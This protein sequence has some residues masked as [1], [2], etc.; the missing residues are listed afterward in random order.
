MQFT[1]LFA[2][3]LA[4]VASARIA[5]RAASSAWV[6]LYDLPAGQGRAENLTGL[7]LKTPIAF[8]TNIDEWADSVK[9]QTGFCVDIYQVYDNG[10]CHNLQQTTCEGILI[11]LTAPNTASCLILRPEIEIS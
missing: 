9:A 8:G 2:L 10:Q 5:T 11:D 7:P 6:T 3:S 1:T 4:T